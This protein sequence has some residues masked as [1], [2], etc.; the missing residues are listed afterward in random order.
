MRDT[1]RKTGLGLMGSVLLMVGL[2]FLTTAAWIVLEAEYG[3]ATAALVLG[4][5]YTG[6][7]LVAFAATGSKKPQAR[8]AQE[9]GHPP[10]SSPMSLV[11][12]A[13]LDG[14]GSGYKARD[15]FRR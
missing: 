2:G 8:T 5:I 13:F 10:S 11:L 3:A 9:R 15:E 1:A 14:L 7:A 6:L 4:C 12:T